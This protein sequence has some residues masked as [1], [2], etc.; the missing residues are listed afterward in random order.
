MF[1][2]TLLLGLAALA[3]SGEAF[4]FPVDRGDPAENANA[5]DLTNTSTDTDAIANAIVQVNQKAGATEDVAPPNQAPPET[6]VT[7]VD[8]NV[9]DTVVPVSNALTRRSL[10]FLPKRAS[11]AKF[12]RQNLGNYKQV[13]AGTGTGPD[14]RDGSIQGTAYLTYTLVPNNT[15]S[16][17]P[18]LAFCDRVP[19]CVFANLYYEYNNPGLDHEFS[20]GSN[21]KCAIYGDV[22]TAAEKTNTGGQQLYPAPGGLTYIQ[23]SSGY[24][25][26]QWVDI[27]TPDGYEQ[28]FGPLE[29]ANNAPGYMGFAFLDRYD[30]QACAD[31]CNKRGVDGNGGACKFFNI[32]RAVFSDK[33][34]TYTCSMYYEV[35]DASTANNYGQGDLKVTQSRGYRRKSVVPDGDFESYQCPDGGDFC[36][37]TSTS[38]WTATSPAGGN[39]D[40][41]IFHYQPYAHSGNS[42][43]LLGSAN[44]ADLFPGT[45]K[46][47]NRLDTVPGKTYTI[48]FFTSSVYSG[49]VLQRDAYVTVLW[50]GQEVQTFHTEYAPWT[51]RE[52]TVTASG[53]DELAFTGG[54]STAYTFIDGV[55]VFQA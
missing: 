22:H 26:E 44:G 39:L 16:I 23:Q 37:T 8:G 28:V 29:A 33:P 45:L 41:T 3:I 52:V 10:G 15:Y 20:E 11:S 6:V 21:L 32:W 25:L 53:N 50:N 1:P 43:A 5:L 34:Q 40:A 35:T 27:S 30:V 13:F 46:P 36:Y 2:S 42:V 14:D 51:Y 18:C 7:A 31:L 9:L 38:T 4:K 48:Q 54:K 55:Y 49:P 47:A 17:E 12:R 19:G 24:A